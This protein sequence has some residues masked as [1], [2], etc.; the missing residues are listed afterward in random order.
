MTVKDG[1]KHH[2]KE[3]N[4]FGHIAGYCGSHA[5]KT[6]L[7]WLLA[8]LAS[9]VLAYS[10]L[11]IDTDPDK[12][13][14]PDLA[15]RK[16]FEDFSHAFPASDNNFLVVVKAPNG[17]QAREASL[18]LVESFRA[19]KDLFTDV[20]APGLGA[21]FDKYGILY[22]PEG[23]IDSIVKKIHQSRQLLQVLSA[24]TNFE[25][26]ASVLEQVAPAAKA[27][28]SPDA[29]AGFLREIRA[30]VLARVKNRNHPLDW[31]AIVTGGIG[32][33]P[34]TWYI[35]V[36]PVLDFSKIDPVELALSEAKRIIND[37]EITRSG[38]IKISLTGEAALNGEEFQSVTQGAAIAGIVSF[39]LVTLIIWL[40]LPVT[41]LIIPALGLLLLGFV[42]NIGFAT[43]AVGSLNMISVAFAVLFI[44]LGIDYAVHSVLR[45]WEERLN[46]RDAL[47][48]I[49]VGAHHAGPALA[50]CTVTTALAFLAFIPSDFV[51]MAQLGIIAAG[52]IVI[53]FIA[54][55]TLVPALLAKVPVRVKPKHLHNDPILPK[56]VWQH[57]KL[58]TTVFIVMVAIAA[59]ILIPD[60]R[61]DGDP[62]NLKDPKAPS[63]IAFHELLKEQ[64]GAAYAAQVIV[65]DAEKAEKT[66]AR[67]LQLPS[68]SRVRWVDSFLP[69]RQPEKLAR[70]ATLKD[71][72]T[73]HPGN[74]KPLSAQ[75]RRAALERIKA[76][77]KAI[78]SSDK[79]AKQLH[80]E[81][82]KLRQALVLLDQPK[83][84]T[85]NALMALE[86]DIFL[87]L[88]GLLQQ[89][90]TMAVTQPLDVQSLDVDISRRYVTGDGRW[91][92]EVIP[93]NDVTN[94][95]ALRQFVSEV[96]QIAPQVTGS[97]VEITGA[98]DVVSRAMGMAVLIAFGLVLVVLV[99]V[100]RSFVSIALVLTPLVLSALLLLAYTVIFKSPFNFAN[101]IV[102]PLL[103]GLGV[104][105]AIHYV[106]RAR[107][108]GAAHQVV[109]T[110]TPRAVFIS[111]LTTVGS[112]GTLW[113]SPHKGTSSMGELLTIAIIITLVNT[114][115]VL[116]Q[117]IAWTIGRKSAKEPVDG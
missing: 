7:V 62:I 46:G 83:S 22:L 66:A 91:R 58:G 90:A 97:P 106:M 111:A 81:T 47:V 74:I 1:E 114:L 37:P 2:T 34:D 3:L 93:A 109:D 96:R 75:K 39:V 52:G 40:G 68:V 35:S 28:K 5:G 27:G 61:F 86:R 11:S 42:V 77:L 12:M 87:Q 51:G 53:A 71:I 67:L 36:K 9:I 33:E 13:I 117:F 115:I 55:L 64:P 32:R 95:K 79:V 108:D 116:P 10:S 31:T 6:L 85:N 17:D 16:S 29:L 92:L 89:L 105:S 88:P 30:S 41:R 24:N 104:D 23:D 78:E 18:A 49:A 19:R 103:V 50:L 70:L 8:A 102:L 15:F 76:A 60:V 94:E 43:L 80:S 25:G 56:P 98:A 73:G 57:I 99:P 63:V 100:L 65:E 21:F 4:V 101:V 14:S 72:L 82:A 113:L 69:A 44:G 112:F 45:Y 20:Y 110:T 38:K 59:I 48:A 26:L 107:E 54:S 84:A